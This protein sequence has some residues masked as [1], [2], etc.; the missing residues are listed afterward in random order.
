MAASES[1][2]P[3]LRTFIASVIHELRTPL[4]AL[5][6]EVEIALRRERSP[7]TYRDALARISQQ[8]AELIELTGD[9]AVFGD[10]DA[11]RGL[12][13]ATTDLSALATE[14]SQHYDPGLVLVAITPDNIHVAGDTKLLTRAF[15]L[16]LD[17]AVHYRGPGSPVHLR[18][19]TGEVDDA[20][21][22]VDLILDASE[23]RF[24]PR[25]WHYLTT[26]EFDR[27]QIGRAGLIRLRTASNIVRM[28]GGAVTVHGPEGPVRV[29][30]RL[31]VKSGTLPDQSTAN[32]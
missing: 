12:S 26:D 23:P 30:L 25:T 8:A 15:R 22:S 19:A 9:L 18:T 28:S 21:G 14:L 13:E 10:P 5:S 27:E 24:S 29:R 20:P 2:G 31:R 17:H 32:P 6:T 7:A 16:L 3:S 4:S 11:F 1:T